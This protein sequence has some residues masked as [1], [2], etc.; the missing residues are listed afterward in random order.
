M[1]LSSLIGPAR[2]PTTTQSEID[3]NLPIALYNENIVTDLLGNA[4]KCQVCLCDYIA[5]E[6]IRV[7]NCRHGFHKEC[8]DKVSSLNRWF[9][10]FIF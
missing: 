1:L 2:P 6:E 7:L 10:N 8:I 4:E 5:D 9:F 3:A